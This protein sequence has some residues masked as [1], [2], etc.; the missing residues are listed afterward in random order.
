MQILTA[1]MMLS[2]VLVMILI[3]RASAERITEILDEESD[4]KNKENPINEVK[5]GSIIF[6]NV[7]FSYVKDKNRT[8][9]KDINIEIKSG[10]TIG[11]IGGTGSSKTTFVSLIPRLFDATSRKS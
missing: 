7:S 9:L 6:E 3:S 1:L 10:E 11:I 2:M 4:I 8:C 5:D